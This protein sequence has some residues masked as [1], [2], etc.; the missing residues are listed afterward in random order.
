P[1]PA[2]YDGMGLTIL[3]MTAVTRSIRPSG[4]EGGRPPPHP[5]TQGRFFLPRPSRKTRTASSPHGRRDAGQTAKAHGLDLTLGD[6]CGQSG[7]PTLAHSQREV[8]AFGIAGR[9]VARVTEALPALFLAWQRSDNS[10][11]GL[12]VA[13]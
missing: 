2:V 9:G 6:G 4:L 11:S 7:E 1:L 8:L 3:N 13:P 5:P 10:L 12:P